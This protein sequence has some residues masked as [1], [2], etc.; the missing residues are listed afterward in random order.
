MACLAKLK[1]AIL[2]RSIIYRLRSS[3]SQKESSI[4]L[5]WSQYRVT[6]SMPFAKFRSANA[7]AQ[8]CKLAE[9]ANGMLYVTL[10]WDHSSG[11]EDPFWLLVLRKW[12]FDR[13][14]EDCRFKFGKARHTP[15]TYHSTLNGL[16]GFWGMGF[17]GLA[18]LPSN[19]LRPGPRS[20]YTTVRIAEYFE[21]IAWEGSSKFYTVQCP[22]NFKLWLYSLELNR[23][24]LSSRK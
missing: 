4:P 1:A 6:Y 14:Q 3:K 12:I 21:I 13:P 17:C 19:S 22:L 10:Y 5:L 8:A 2:L 7:C 11:I 18:L 24:T 20:L 15:L 9:R 23:N 16:L